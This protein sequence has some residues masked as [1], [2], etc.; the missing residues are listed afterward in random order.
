VIFGL[1]SGASDLCLAQDCSM[2]FS[3]IVLS[4]SAPARPDLR[5]SHNLHA[6]E[7]NVCLHVNDW[8]LA[9]LRVW[10]LG[11]VTATTLVREG[12]GANPG[13]AFLGRR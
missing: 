4:E 2:S 1:L 9:A 6:L 12:I 3:L 7:P 8:A 5:N 11:H 13:H 10:R